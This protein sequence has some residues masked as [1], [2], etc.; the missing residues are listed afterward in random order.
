MSTWSDGY[1]TETGYTYG[2]YREISPLFLRFCLLL[3]GFDTLQPSPDSCHCELGFGQG[4]SVNIHAASTPGS[5]IATDFNA[6]HAFAAQNMVQASGAKAALYDDSFEQLLNRQDLPQFDSIC[7]HGIW[8]W[9]ST[10]NHKIIVEFARRHLKPGGIFY[11]SYNCFPGWAPAYPLRQIMALHDRFMGSP[12]DAL[13]RVGQALDFTARLLETNPAYSLAVP[14]L[15]NR[16]E[17][18]QKQDKSYI[19]HEYFNREWNCMYFTDVVEHL[20]AA[21]LEFVASAN[22]LDYVDAVNLTAEAQAFL[23]DIPSPI[24]REQARDYFVSAQ[25]RKDIFVRGP[26][27][28]SASEQSARLQETRV[29]LLCAAEDV[30]MT[31]KGACGE[32]NLHEHIYKP[33]L[34][35]L[36]DKKY[37]P[38]TLRELKQA[39]P[40]MDFAS[41]LS[42]ITVL[43]G[44]GHVQPCQDEK[45]FLKTCKALN[46]HLME[47]AVHS[48]E[49][50]YLASPVL[51]G[52]VTLSRFQLLFCLALQ[53][54]HKKPEDWAAY[55]WQVL[56]AQGQKLVK[57]G[58]TLESAEENTQELTEQAVHFGEKRLAILKALLVA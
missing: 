39:L 4:V 25:F 36:A 41:L 33:L 1:F 58:V 6:S 50:T 15:K 31:V 26:R 21:K 18:I 22:P 49:I 34:A 23:K 48:G 16:L 37:A 43:A 12:G 53:K 42:A 32:A 11:I 20:E 13:N 24:F 7:L 2:Y 45:P 57:N 19:A 5:Y 35:A 54:G 8:T 55:V 40:E 28:L 44:A 52:A 3:K 56:S 46:Q 27:K 14:N 38:K 47:R 30:S 17:G 9:I 10:E 51:G 29:A